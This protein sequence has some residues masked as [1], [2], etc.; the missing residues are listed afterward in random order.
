M[1]RI[2]AILG[3]ALMGLAGCESA[4]STPQVSPAT[5]AAFKIGIL[6]PLSGPQTRLG[7]DQ[8]DGFNLYFAQHPTIAGRAVELI[9]EDDASQPQQGLAKTRKLL[10]QDQVD[11][12]AGVVNSAV[13]D[14]VKGQITG[15]VPLVVTNAGT[16]SLTSAPVS[17]NA[18]RISHSNGQ[19]NRALGWYAYEKL[20]LRKVSVI[21]YDFLA[22]AEQAAGFKAVFTALGGTVVQ[23]QKVPLGAADLSPY[24]AKVDTSVDALYV[25]LAGAEAVK[26][27]QQGQSYGLLKKMKVFGPGFTVDDHVLAAA[28]G[29]T[30]G[31]TGAIQYVSTIDTRTNTDFV[32]AF[33]AKYGY[34]PPVYSQDAYLGAAVIAAALQAAKGDMSGTRFTDA[35]AKVKVD[36]PRG[37]FQ[38]DANHQ[39][40]L[41]VY[42]YN[43]VDQDGSPAYKIVD[44]L[45]NV[46][47]NWNPP[48]R[49]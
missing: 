6:E 17:K 12:I 23:E 36:S 27:F 44:K 47:Q 8:V 10:E 3:L 24:V 30:L 29:A 7:K 22:G 48:A 41:T 21:T 38:F 39:A 49:S 28:K 19:P 15:R 32:T 46:S 26:F 20:H 31:F 9:I 43:V 11:V 1:R 40:M 37:R 45:E 2:S 18:W 16:E 35:L 25:F 34:A 33:K 14:A 4:A 42:F 13:L 5:S